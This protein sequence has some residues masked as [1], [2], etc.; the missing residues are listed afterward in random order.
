M[1]KTILLWTG[2]MLGSQITKAQTDYVVTVAKDTV[3]AEI[4][5]WN[6]T[7]VICMVK[8]KETKYKAKEIIGFKAGDSYNEI[9]R[10]CPTI[11]GFKKKMILEKLISGKIS[12][13]TI[14]VVD[15]FMNNKQNGETQFTSIT[16]D[17]KYIKKINDPKN[18]F[19]K[20]MG[21]GKI[22]KMTS[23]CEKYKSKYD[24]INS[25]A[26]YPYQEQIEFYNQ[27]CK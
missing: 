7:R 9:A 17:V 16:S 11:I 15:H 14:T 10:V 6:S 23:D 1:K 25:N 24:N 18:K 26:E 8:G 2:L 20:L 12:L 5:E 19:K 3:K 27:N 4:T 22:K 13:Y 21:Y